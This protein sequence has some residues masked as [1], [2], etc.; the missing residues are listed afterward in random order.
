MISTWSASAGRNSMS[1]SEHNQG[2]FSLLSDFADQS[3]LLVGP[4]REPGIAKQPIKF[5]SRYVVAFAGALPQGLGLENGDMAA[6]IPDKPRFLQRAHHIGD[7][8][9]PDTE[10]HPQ[11]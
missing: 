9:S 6:P 5:L 2:L 10:H 11:E 3:M 4:R 7:R 1:E 8:G